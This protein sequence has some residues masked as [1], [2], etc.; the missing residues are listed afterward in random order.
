MLVDENKSPRVIEFK[1]KEPKK[2]R[3]SLTPTKNKTSPYRSKVEL[4]KAI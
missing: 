3:L 2:V 4:V 1:P